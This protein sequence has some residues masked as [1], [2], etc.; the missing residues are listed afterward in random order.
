[1]ENTQYTRCCSND[2]CRG[3]YESW[4]SPAGDAR[5]TSRKKYYKKIGKMVT[6]V[7]AYLPFLGYSCRV[8]SNPTKENTLMVST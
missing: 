1:M 6:F 8:K 7:V 2:V 4:V 5:W 3:H